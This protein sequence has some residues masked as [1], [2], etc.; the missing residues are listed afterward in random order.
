MIKFLLTSIAVIFLVRML[1]RL[2][3]QG[4]NVKIEKHYYYHHTPKQE[5]Q[6]HEGYTTLNQNTAEGKQV[7]YSETEGEY[8]PYEEVKE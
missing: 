8:V 4:F 7:K 5:A 3:T 2:L 1:I 6:K